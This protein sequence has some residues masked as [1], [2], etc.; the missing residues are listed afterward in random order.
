MTTVHEINHRMTAYTKG[1]VD[2]L[3]P[4]CT[5]ILTAEGVRPI[6]DEDKEQI[7]ALCLSMSKEA[8][9]VLGFAMRVLP[10]LPSDDNE[11]VEFDLTF[12]GVT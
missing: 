4:L 8:L 2:E 3:L 7:A 9:R 6:T 12:I 11:N 10:A 1:A 5:R